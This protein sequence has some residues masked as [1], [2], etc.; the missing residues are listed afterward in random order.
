MSRFV[1]ACGGTGGHLAPGIALAEWLSE[2]GHSTLLLISNK[3]IDAQL[4]EKYPNLEFAVVPG[5]PLVMDAM[6]LI[7]FTYHQARGL[8]FSWRLLHR[9]RPAA[10][11]G[12]GGFTTASIIVAGWLRGVPVALHEAN[13]VVGRAVR[14]LA[15]F[16]QRVYV[17]R[18]VSLPGTGDDK[19]RHAGLPVR[20]E[21]KRIPR[22]EA[23]ELF[24]LDA[25]LPTVVVMGGSQG[26]RALN[27]W[28]D[29]IAPELAKRGV[30]LLV[31]AGPSQGESTR[32]ELPGPDGK[33]IKSIQISFCDQMAALYSVGDIVVSR[34]G[35]GTLA[36]LM[37]CRVP[38]VLVPYPHATD[39]HQEANA[40][41]FVRQGGGVMILEEDLVRLDDEVFALVE[42]ESR[43]AEIR[44]QLGHMGR[45]QALDLLQH[46][47]EVLAGLRSAGNTLAPWEAVNSS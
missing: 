18:G 1:I 14:S 11:I 30:Q 13:R 45:A 47:I 21:I 20:T 38:A 41:E 32:R 36:E 46:D 16:A 19:L 27:K 33:M 35:A 29:R 10:I 42:N 40:R 6:G 31:V 4:T 12:F 23:A 17:P 24:D 8:W 43:L 26:A 5:A 28:S 44:A 25:T 22:G 2:G 7:K 39:A 15:R 9:D 3:S 34:S 37:R